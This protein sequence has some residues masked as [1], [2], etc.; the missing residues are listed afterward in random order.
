MADCMYIVNAEAAIYKDDKWLVVKRSELE[1]HVPGVLAL[2]GG[3]IE[4]QAET[5]DVL[6]TNLRREISEE[7]GIE[8][9]E[10]FHYVESKSFQLDDGRFV[11]DLVFLCKYASGR[12]RPASPDEVAEVH[13]MTTREI[14]GSKKS[15]DW[16][17][18]NIEKAEQVRSR[19]EL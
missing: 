12:P 6:E 8:V 1:E 9:A 5:N 7:V 10:V 4:T 2:V 14:L 18:Q 13:W 17:K 16:L 11:I 15:P 3:K 19:V